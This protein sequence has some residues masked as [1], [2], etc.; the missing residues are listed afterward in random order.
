MSCEAFEIVDLTPSK[1]PYMFTTNEDRRRIIECVKKGDDLKEI[2]KHLGIKIKTCRAIAATGR[3]KRLKPGSSR[4]KFDEVYVQRLCTLVD[5][6]PALTLRQ[7]KEQIEKDF[8]EITISTSSIDR[9][10]DGHHYTVKKMVIQPVERNTDSTK[11]KRVVYANWLKQ[12]GSSVLRIYIDE[13]N[14]NIWCS[15]NYGRSKA[16]QSCVRTLPSNKG[17]NLNIMACFSAGGIQYHE[18]HPRLTSQLFN[19]FLERC[20]LKIAEE[21]PGV[22]VVFI[23]DNAPIHRQAIQAVLCDNHSIKYL[24]PY[25]PFFNPLEEAFSKFKKVCCHCL[26]STPFIAGY[27][28]LVC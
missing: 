24:P 13:T 18:Y 4:V 27:Q 12:S 19:E 14:Y 3:E 8:S 21:Q 26:L 28:R 25:S 2:S 11:E 7:L 1:R 15:R 9:L 20:S 17:P 10:L 16:A 22:D 23:F 5:N 6:N